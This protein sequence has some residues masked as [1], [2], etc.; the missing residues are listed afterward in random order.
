MEQASAQKDRRDRMR[1]EAPAVD[2]LSTIGDVARIYGLTLRALRF[3]EDRGLVR[4][5]RHGVSRFYDASARARIETIL[6][7]KQLGF[8]LQQIAELIS[9]QADTGDRPQLALEE[10]QV[11][12][13]ITQLERKRSDLDAAIR[14]LRD[15]HLQMTGGGAA[16]TASAA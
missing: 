9:G 6:R 1:E 8:T 3:Y 4:P 5:I 2:R 12:S 11:I 13:Q 14:E 15:V 10:A 7:G 16:D